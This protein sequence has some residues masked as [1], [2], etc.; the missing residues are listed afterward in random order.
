MP[1]IKVG[2]GVIARKCTQ[3]SDECAPNR[4]LCAMHL[5]LSCERQKRRYAANPA[6]FRKI[7]REYWTNRSPESK[8]KSYERR[9]I[10]YRENPDQ[11]RNY[12]MKRRYGITLDDYFELERKQGGLCALCG[13]RPLIGKRAPGREKQ[14]PRLYVDHDHKSGRVRGLLC[15][16]CNTHT[17]AGIEKSGVSLARI[18]AYLQM[19]VKCHQA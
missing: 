7:G 18:A 17:V 19:E 9:K 10:Q 15:H 16:W 2:D 14:P 5:R 4:S 8:A 1:G 11:S 3:C 12:E 6:K 13:Q